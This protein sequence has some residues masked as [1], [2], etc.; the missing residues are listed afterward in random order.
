[1]KLLDENGDLF[2]GAMFRPIIISSSTDTGKLVAELTVSKED[3]PEHCHSSILK[4][5]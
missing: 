4:H 3:K 1:M 2:F 5:F